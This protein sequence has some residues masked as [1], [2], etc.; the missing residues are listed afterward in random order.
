MLNRGG[1]ANSMPLV[2]A[3]G[4]GEGLLLGDVA[5]D[6]IDRKIEAKFVDGGGS[7]LGNVEEVDP[8]GLFEVLGE[9][10]QPGFAELGELLEGGGELAFQAAGV[11]GDVVSALDV[12]GVVGE[13]A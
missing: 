13:D 8:G 3:D 1:P 6:L 11:D 4:L 2:V 7:F 12:G 5:L 10:S 9:L